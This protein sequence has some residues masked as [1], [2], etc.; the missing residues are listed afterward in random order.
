[1]VPDNSLQLKSSKTMKKPALNRRNF[2]KR[3]SAGMLGA[4]IIGNRTLNPQTEDPEDE[5]PMIRGYKTLG[6][7]GFK[8]SDISL[9]VFF[10]DSIP[11]AA[12]ST[13]INLIETGEMYG[14]GN[15]ERSLGNL[16][17]DLKRED[18]FI[19]TKISHTVKEYQTP[20]EVIARA[21]A[22]MERL[23]TDYLNC[24]MMHG[25]VS[26]EMVLNEAF[27]KGVDRLQTDGKVRFRGVSCHGHSWWD[28]PAETYEEV[29]MTA[30]N[31]GRF[32]VILF[33][34]NFFER[35]MGERIIEAAKKKDI[36]TLAMKSNPIYEFEYFDNYKKETEEKGETLSERYAMVWGKFKEQT[37]NSGKFS[38]K[39]GYESMEEMKDAAIQFILGNPDMHSICFC[40]MNLATIE[41]YIRLS[42]TTLDD[43]KQAMLDDFHRMYGP[44]QCRIGCNLCEPACPHRIPVGTI[45]RYSYY[46]HG[47]GMEKYAMQQYHELS[48]SKPDVCLSCQGYCQQAC[49]HGV[50]IQ[51]LLALAHQSLAFNETQYT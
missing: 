7:T 11:R 48:G 18:L 4:G 10:S 16:I 45:M 34:Y 43:G 35:E 21:E 6:R 33:P 42:G 44:L 39:Y 28:N 38:N 2:L 31:D 8:V 32:D 51:G 1:L 37:E 25:A 30:I 12:L 36:G 26:S 50:Q 17:P 23:Q 49:P 46:F 15:Q 40:F 3:S 27:H 9:G 29:L 19:L 20:D 13:G 47:K 41:K 5:P 22:S 14:R 24:Y